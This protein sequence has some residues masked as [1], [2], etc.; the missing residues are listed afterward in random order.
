M[1]GPFLEDD[2]V[3]APFGADGQ[4]GMPRK[5]QGLGPGFD[6]LS[7]AGAP[8]GM[9]A[10]P[11]E[12]EDELVTNAYKIGPDGSMMPD[13]DDEDQ[14]TTQ[15]SHQ[16]RQNLAEV[17]DENYLA[18]IGRDLIEQIEQDIEDRSPWTDRFRKG[19][20]MLGLS[21]DEMDDGPFPGASTA[22][23]PLISEAI[24]QFWARAMGEQVPSTGPVKS[25]ALGQQTQAKLERGRRIEDYM[26][27]ELLYV[28]DAWYSEHSR[29]MFA[30]PYQ[31][32][33]FKKIYHDAVLGKNVSVY[34]PAEDFL[35]PSSVTDLMSAPRF[36]HR[37]WRTHNELR[38]M[39]AAGVYRDIDLG[40]PDDEDLPEET[41]IRMEV[42]DR[43]LSSSETGDPTTRHELLECYCDLDLPGYEEAVALPY[44]VTVDRKTMKVLSVYR[45]WKEADVNKRRRVCFVKYEY[46]PGLGFYGL[47]LLHLLGGLQQAATGAVR[48]LLDAGATASLQGGFVAKDANIR[49]QRLVVEPGIW[50]PVDSTSEEL[51]KAFFTPPFREPSPALFQLLGFLT[52]RAEK[53][54]AT[55]ELMTGETNAKAP[56]GSTIAVIEQAAKVF[57]TIH[58][59]LHMAMAEE[60]RLRF[61]L[62]QENMPPGGYPYDVDGSHDGLFEDDFEAGVSITPVSD[63]NIFSSAQR[64][65]IAQAVYQLAM[66]NPDTIKKDVA[67][68][69][70]LEAIRAPDV[71]ELLI[72]N[73]PPPPMD[74]VSEIQ[75]ILRGQPVQAYPDQLHIAHLQHYSSFLQNPG[76]GA[77]PEVMKAAGPQIMALVGQRLA[78]AWATQARQFGAPAPLLP[79]PMQQ[80][81]APQAGGQQ[82]QPQQPQIPPEQI[83]QM[84]AQIAPQMAQMAQ[85]LPQPPDPKAQQAQQQMALKEQELQMKQKGQD[86]ELQFK[87]QSHA[88]DMQQSQEK[89]Q[90]EMQREMQKAH[91]GL[92]TTVAQAEAD[93]M[94]SE[95]ESEQAINDAVLSEQERTQQMLS[96]QAEDEL[97]RDMKM[98]DMVLGRLASDQERRQRM[99][100]AEIERSI[101]LSDAQ[102]NRRLREEESKSKREA[103]KKGGQS[104]RPERKGR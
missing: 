32:S 54:T 15:S 99:D 36:T 52:D 43:Q 73:E 89:H 55:T 100:D 82:M 63:P 53:F 46:V 96:R 31:G 35:V 65:A 37:I 81:N 74:P 69:R 26:N 57:S 59:G 86:A 38:K 48:Q 4:L 77:H 13:I 91:I 24:V 34:V 8:D 50:K 12:F 101:R 2:D 70:V 27:H 97:N 29:T 75:A 88:Q 93:Q 102:Q 72:K 103:A 67:V 25:K 16:H 78:Y 47:G 17:I 68:R 84:A 80:E 49:D 87:S 56:V 71:E 90:F 41:E 19:M 98:Q 10:M 5:P 104:G 11:I 60:L 30:V 21:Q 3:F 76:F 83:A 23:H 45:N 9:G 85:G 20:E 22:V 42:Q 95:L 39:I 44:V 33:A 92:A 64:V 40:E 66:E 7:I 6:P 61:E 79:P 58:R 28:D 62:I 94:R 18:K 14:L 51:Q 1:A